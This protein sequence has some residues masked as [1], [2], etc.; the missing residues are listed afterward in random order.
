MGWLLQF[1]PR[2]LRAHIEK[3]KPT[4]VIAVPTSEIMISSGTNRRKSSP[5]M[6]PLI[7]SSQTRIHAMLERNQNREDRW[8]FT[9]DRVRDANISQYDQNMT[10]IPKMIH[11]NKF[12]EVANSNNS[13]L[14]FFI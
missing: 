8:R 7:K 5:D 6:K 10:Q 11:S 9:S 3:P 1:V 12:K 13:I 14:V 2:W 4:N